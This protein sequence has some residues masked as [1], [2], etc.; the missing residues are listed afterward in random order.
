M[1]RCFAVGIASE[2][3]EQIDSLERHSFCDAS[4]MGYG[5]V[6]YLRVKLKDDKIFTS[7]IMSKART[8][9]LGHISIPRLEFQAA[10]VC[11][12]VCQLI[13]RE[14]DLP[15]T[16][17]NVILWTDSSFVLQYRQYQSAV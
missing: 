8:A 5:T 9:P 14:I 7:L 10:T 4:E 15:I 11:A 1:G 12:R 16:I 3:A 13:L 17:D 6:S 2:S